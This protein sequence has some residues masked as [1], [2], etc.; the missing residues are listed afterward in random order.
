VYSPYTLDLNHSQA[1]FC[2]L[3]II[4]SFDDGTIPHISRRR[5][6][7]ISCSVLSPKF[8]EQILN[9]YGVAVVVGTRHAVPVL[10]VAT[11]VTE[12]KK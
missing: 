2:Q 4:F 1:I 3:L 6:S 9:K 8:M 10:N 12:R 11:P 5:N 7:D